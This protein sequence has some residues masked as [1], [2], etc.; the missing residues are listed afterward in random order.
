V[1][2][3]AVGHLPRRHRAELDA[4]AAD[5]GSE[6]LDLRMLETVRGVL[7]NYEEDRRRA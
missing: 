2:R 7:P 3:T 1:A 6:V 5:R 4:V